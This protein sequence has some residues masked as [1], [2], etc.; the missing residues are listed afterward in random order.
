MV[1]DGRNPDGSD[2]TGRMCTA[3]SDSLVDAEKRRQAN[4]SLAWAR[5]EVLDLIDSL[6]NAANDEDFAE[7]TNRLQRLTNAGEDPG[8]RLAVLLHM[9]TSLAAIVDLVDTMGGAIDRTD[10]ANQLRP[11]LRACLHEPKFHGFRH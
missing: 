5:L 9:S 7:V 3:D 8:R 2:A 4:S 6:L 10:F 11:V 1:S